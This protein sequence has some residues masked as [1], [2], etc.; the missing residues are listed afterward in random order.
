MSNA[1]LLVVIV[2][3]NSQKYIDWAVGSLINN[4]LCH[5]RIVDSGSADISYLRK[6]ESISNADVIYEENLG[7]AKANNRALHDVSKFKYVLFLNPDARIERD[8]LEELLKRAEE[9]ENSFVGLFSV[10]LEKFSIAD[11]KPLAYYDSLGIYCDKL[12][13]WKDIQKPINNEKNKINAEAV[14]GAFMLCRT[15]A[16]V[17][18]PDSKGNIGFEESYYM[19]KE[20]IE[21]SLRIR[22]K[23]GMKLFEDINAYHCRGWAGSRKSNP[24]WARKQSAIN[25]V[26]VAAHYKYRALP[27]ALLKYIYVI[28][29]EKK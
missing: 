6:L 9:P 4:K 27:Y 12:G 1:K 13:R 5:I 17:S 7:F 22:K 19:Y 28:M 24:Y 10:G 3:Y 21:L 18:V 14:C 25:D 2:T 11:N 26:H 16:L 29:V 23:W 20:D 8:Q 15:D